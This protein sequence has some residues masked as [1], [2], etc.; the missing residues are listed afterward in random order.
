MGGNRTALQQLPELT[1]LDVSHSILKSHDFLRAIPHLSPALRSLAAE[2]CALF[3]S[4]NDAMERFVE[5]C[6]QLQSLRYG[7]L[8][9][10]R[11]LAHPHKRDRS[12]QGAVRDSWRWVC[13]N[14]CVWCVY[15]AQGWHRW[16][17]S[18]S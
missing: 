11:T 13:T 12:G 14:L 4:K 10:T 16:S 5:R 17:G 18:R 1:H 9:A 6:S 7:R 2:Q 3:T 8:D 15:V